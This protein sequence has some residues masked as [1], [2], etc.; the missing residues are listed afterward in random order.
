MHSTPRNPHQAPEAPN[1]THGP[2][3]PHGANLVDFALTKKNAYMANGKRPPPP[4]G[5][6]GHKKKKWV[7]QKKTVFFKEKSVF[8]GASKST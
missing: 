3:G 5:G 8:F 1:L 7:G 4:F 2:D 6:P